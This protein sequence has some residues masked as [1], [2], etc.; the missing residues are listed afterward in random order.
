MRTPTHN[1]TN[2]PIC[3]V[4]VL[5]YLQSLLPVCVS[6][7]QMKGA[8]AGKCHSQMLMLPIGCSL[9]HPVQSQCLCALQHPFSIKRSADV[10]ADPLQLHLLLLLF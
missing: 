9:R 10:I 7:H 1:F 5:H 4:W 2:T 6:P 8:K 3:V